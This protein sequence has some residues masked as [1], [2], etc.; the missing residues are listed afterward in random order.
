MGTVTGGV[1]LVEHQVAGAPEVHRPALEAA[2]MAHTGH[3]VALTAGGVELARAVVGSPSAPAGPPAWRLE[4]SPRASRRMV[5]LDRD[6]TLIED[7]HYLADP[8]GVRLLPGALEGL[9]ALSAAGIRAAVLT[10]QS[11]VARG[12]IT[13]AQLAAVHDRLSALL[14]AGGVSLAGIFSCLHAPDAGCACRKPAEGLARQAAD[15]LGFALPE[16]VV[17]GDKASDLELGHRLGVP[18]ILVRTGEGPATLQSGVV[19]ADYLVDDLT[20]VARLLTHPAGLP[21]PARVH[22]G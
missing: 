4:F 22:A 10:N 3:V 17:V 12:R 2:A 13:P 16:A 19:S 9:R 21:V 20:G 15:A 11:G 18:A 6:G 1:T 7:R 5:L 8:Q 14:G